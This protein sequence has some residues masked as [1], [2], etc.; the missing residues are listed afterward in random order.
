[1]MTT[2]LRFSAWSPER[3]TIPSSHFTLIE[4]LVVIAIIA[5]LAAMLLPAL[6]KAR[7]A[8]QNITCVNLLKQQGTYFMFYSGDN[9]NVVVPA[10]LMYADN[11]DVWWHR[12]MRAYNY[13]FFTRRGKNSSGK[14]TL[15]SAPPVCPSAVK[16]DKQ[17]YSAG[18]TFNLYEGSFGYYGASYTMTGICGYIKVNDPATQDRYY[19]LKKLNQVKNPTRKLYLFDGYSLL[20]LPNTT[21][22]AALPPN[23]SFFA[24]SRHNSVRLAINTLFMDG[25]VDKVPYANPS[26]PKGGT[27]VYKYYVDLLEEL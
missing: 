23:E 19:R 13:S 22:F 10:R 9:N 2:K 15:A 27:T 5:I 26:D 14:E 18:G 11:T 8:A 7:E 20:V 17:V 16:E 12:L 24:W 6:N 1:M 4:L 21:R 3:Q 25:H